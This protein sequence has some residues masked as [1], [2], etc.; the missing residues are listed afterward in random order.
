MKLLLNKRLLL[1]LLGVAAVLILL[2]FSRREGEAGEGLYHTANRG[3]LIVSIIEGGSIEAVNEVVVK[4]S[5]EG[6][7]QIITLI[8]EGS[9][10]Q[11]GDLLVEFDKSQAES[12]LQEAQVK[13]ESHQAEVVKATND[14]LITRSTVDSELRAAKLAVE[15]AQMDLEKFKNL[16]RDHKIRDSE[17]NIDTQEEALKLAQQRYEWSEKLAEKG[18]ET[19]SQVDRDRLEVSKSSKAV[20]TAKSTYEMLRK[21]DL[22]K[23][24]A[25]YQ[26]AL[27][28]AEA[29]L[30]RTR[31]EG[32]SKIAQQEAAVNSAKSTLRITQEQLDRAKTQ[33]EATK[34]YA[35]QNGLVIYA[36]SD[37]RWDNEPEIAEGSKIRN[38]R[39]VIKIPDTSKLKVQVKIHESMISQ[40]AVGQK[41]YVVLDSL[42]DQR[43]RGE[44][45][46]VAILPD[47]DRGW[48]GGDDKKV[49]STEIVIL[50]EMKDIKPGVSARAEIVIQELSNVISVPIQAVTTQN[51]KQVCYLKGEDEPTEIEVG[52]FNTKFI[53]VKSGLNPGDQVS[54]NPPLDKRLNLEGDTLDLEDASGET[55][56]AA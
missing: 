48:R 11:E 42:P 55:E 39:D 40:I 21:F 22:E 7:S 44:V 41:A 23:E 17:L 27:Q 18:F 43:F 56:P 26:S 33:L 36:K 34:L 30:E 50:D 10:V 28:E 9:Y 19:K 13:Y 2:L 51:G 24:A 5:I 53:E 47:S 35:P 38:R 45:S 54:L 4:N 29:K 3:D 49:Y 31:K 16:E 15:F 1:P 25:T 37:R 20:E 52:L 6:E 12:T 8:P 46:K 14:L 32:E